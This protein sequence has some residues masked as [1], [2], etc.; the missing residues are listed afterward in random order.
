MKAG[1]ERWIWVIALLV[2]YPLVASP[3][4]VYQIG[5]QSLI[6]GIIAASL[7]FLA[8]QGGMVSL[9]QMTIA[10]I[11]AYMVAI[12]GDSSVAS[13]SLGWPVWLT[14]AV[15][16]VVSVLASVAIGALSIRTDG[17]RTIMITL[18]VGVA[19]FYL[20]QQNL[21]VFNGFQGFS[22]IETPWLFDLDLGNP[23][24]FYYLCA[25]VA[26]L[27]TGVTIYV[28]KTPFGLALQGVR[29][30]PRRMSALG[31][32][33]Q[34]HRI[35]AHAYAG[36]VAGIGGV[37]LVYY[38]HR[39]SPGT[40]HA[41]ALINVLVIAVLGGLRHPIGAF[42]GSLLFILLQNFAIDLV[43]RD[44]FNLVIGAVF[45]FVLMVSPDGLIGLWEKLRGLGR[46]DSQK[47]AATTA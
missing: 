27:V 16:L 14:V 31:F 36:L 26:A 18:A 45:L 13:I 44:R 25:L 34:L 29:D 32:N 20:T 9:S 24:P 47:N 15:A 17:I 19:F 12:F 38:H 3:F 22:S 2:V 28:Q 43:S 41:G 10:G 11:A 7:A 6:L 37:L 21:A 39:V 42:L 8:G 33:V 23:F 35:A 5:A 46:R 1:F 30:N 4:F 40:I